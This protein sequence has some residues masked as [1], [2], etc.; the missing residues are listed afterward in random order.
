[1]YRSKEQT[2]FASRVEAH[3]ASGGAPLLLE[4][5]AGL[6]KTRGYLAPLLATGSPV[7][8]CVPTRALATQLLESGDMA[9]V[10]GG[11]S[12]EIFTP[13]RNFETL[14]QYQVHKQA[15]RA[16]NVLICTHQAALIDV[17]ADGALLDLRERYAVLFD[18]ADQLPDAA[19][20]RFDCA[21]DAYT[22]DL[23]GIKPGGDHRKTINAVLKAL[24]RHLT[25]LDE[26]AAVKAACRGIL[27]A[28]EDPVWYQSV[29]MDEDGS[30]RLVHKLPARVLKRLLTHQ[31]LIF[32]SATLTVNGTFDD[33]KRALGLKDT[34][35]WTTT[36][37]PARHGQLDIISED[38]D[39]DAPNHL[40]KVAEHV[41]TLQGAVLVIVTSHEDAAV[42]GAMIPGAT[43]RGNDV[44]TGQL[45]S[46]GQAA[47]RMTGDASN[48][49][50][51][52]G[53]W[54]GLDTPIRW[55][56][57]V[58]PKAPYGPP[59][60]LDA[61]EVSRYVDS[62]NTA[63]RRFRQGMARGLRSPEA[64]CTLHL[65][66]GRFDRAEFTKALPTRFAQAYRARFGSVELRTRQ[67]EFRK[68]I[69][70]KFSGRCPISGCD[71]PSALEAAHLGSKGGWRT[72]H[73]EGILLRR[74]LHALL[75][76]GKLQ[77]I[78]GV[79]SVAS[80]HYQQFNGVRVW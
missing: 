38:W 1:M 9:A 3:L 18:E 27:D 78:D 47:A 5:A 65:L 44:A 31:R 14:S 50:I 80:E 7:A 62:R 19:A 21:I 48:I 23:L 40:V 34:S 68:N 54:A 2:Q 57:V 72:N 46:T 43:V 75:D 13:R 24:P 59:T 76:A 11:Q 56:H 69:F 79:V 17:L 25:D 29:G 20:L 22:F 30:L 53:A 49:L 71:E 64:V 66:D 74:D 55:R 58:M 67:A 16:A 41:A 35:P 73:T 39:K 12:V 28:L 77:I 61:H 52:A 8:V 6:G 26:P 51:A 36:I 15:C 63:V 32:V 4:G 33:F 60:I 70:E 37:E 45:E 42:L 10:R